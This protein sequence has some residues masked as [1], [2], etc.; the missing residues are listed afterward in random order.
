MRKEAGKALP[1]ARDRLTAL[2]RHLAL[3]AKRIPKLSKKQYL[4][5]VLARVCAP[6]FWRFSVPA[7]LTCV[8]GRRGSPLHDD[9]RRGDDHD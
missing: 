6:P 3:V 1:Q 5:H 8:N 9:A 2:L 7:Q 4:D